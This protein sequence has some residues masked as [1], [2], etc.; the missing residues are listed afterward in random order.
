MGVL[1]SDV[2]ILVEVGSLLVTARIT[3]SPALVSAVASA[4]TLFQAH[5]QDI[6]QDICSA[7]IYVVHGMLAKSGYVV[8]GMLTKSGYVV[9]DMLTKRVW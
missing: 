7:R 8:H 5:A 3:A 4:L 6:L 1:P 9:H 2:A